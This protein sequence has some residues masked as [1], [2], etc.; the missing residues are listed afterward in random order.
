MF[1][2]TFHL[3]FKILWPFHTC[4]LTCI[5]TYHECQL[6]WL[7]LTLAHPTLHLSWNS[8]SQK[9][10]LQLPC[11]LFMFNPHISLKNGWKVI[12][13][14]IGN[15]PVAMPLKK[16]RHPPPE[17]INSLS[18]ANSASESGGAS[19]TYLLSMRKCWLA[20][21][22]PG[23]QARGEFTSTMVTQSCTLSHI[24]LLH[25]SPSSEF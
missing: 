1:I 24:F 10:P 8:S 23:N 19:W 17:T 4:R 2:S 15:L 22:C 14:T 7:S 3:L 18:M 6:L 5:N 16:T 11:L 9:V 25:D 13:Q 12:Y 21:P 20:S